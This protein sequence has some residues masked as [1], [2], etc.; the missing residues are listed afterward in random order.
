MALGQL[1]ELADDPPH[2]SALL[3]G[4]KQEHRAPD[5]RYWRQAVNEARNQAACGE[6]PGSTKVRG[7][8][9]EQD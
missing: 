2:A 4:L 9:D 6:V 3:H 7:S 1:L 8:N 5:N